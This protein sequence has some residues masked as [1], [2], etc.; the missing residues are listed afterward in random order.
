MNRFWPG[1]DIIPGVLHLAYG[2]A[3]FLAIWVGSAPISWA[4]SEPPAV[5]IKTFQFKPTPLGVKAGTPVT[6][7]NNDEITHTV[8]SG[9]PEN[10]DGRFDSSLRGKGTTFSFTFAQPGTYSYFCDRHP[11]MRGEIRV[12]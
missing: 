4:E 6:W 10:H 5:A 2:T 12:N 8:T 7:T 9:T 1:L 3:L 11:S